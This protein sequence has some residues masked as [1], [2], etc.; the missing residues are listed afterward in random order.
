MPNWNFRELYY[1]VCEDV[2][3]TSLTVLA[4]RWS[5]EVVDD[6]MTRQPW[7]FA[8]REGHLLTTA[9]TMLYS[10]PSHWDNITDFRQKDSLRD[11][12]I[13]SAVE[14]HQ[15]IVKPTATGE[16][17]WAI[18]NGIV[19]YSQTPESLI[20]LVS[21]SAADTG[22]VTV[23]GISG[24]W[25]QS[26]SVTLTGI[27]T[28]YTTKRYSRVIS[29]VAG[30]AVTGT[31]T[32]TDDASRTLATIAAA[33]TTA[34][35]TSQP[36]SL[37]SCSSSSTSDDYGTDTGQYLRVRGYNGDD[38]FVEETINL[39]GTTAALSTN[40]FNRYEEI[41]KYEIST[42]TITC[43]SNGGN[44]T[45]AKLAPNQ[46]Q[47]EYVEV[48]FY[49]VPNAA[50]D[51]EVRYSEQPKQMIEDN[52]S[53][54]PIPAKYFNVLKDGVFVKA[55]NYLKYPS[56]AGEAKQSYEFGL[57]GMWLDD[58]RRVNVQTRVKSQN[59]RRVLFNIPR[60]AS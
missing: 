34:T 4:K 41:G 53:F 55:W 49:S 45:I 2:R 14:F 19:G 12:E 42:G 22:T 21:T 11:M 3:D 32:I 38:V 48:G 51:I 28:A 16:P 58:C 36:A 29:D 23:T 26:E 27:T 44:K 6:V 54:H 30:S 18:Y 1:G 5:N 24:G 13:L 35:I 15:R 52:D 20:G 57:K 31:I 47:A 17:Y 56:K 40:Y 10:L 9:D 25:E 46:L 33:G 39:D 43:T 59:E 37:L 7:S 60:N 50:Y 8:K